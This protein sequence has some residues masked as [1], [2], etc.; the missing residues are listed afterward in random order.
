MKISTTVAAF[1]AFLVLTATAQAGPLHIAARGGDTEAIADLLANGAAVHVQDAYGNTPL[2]AAAMN[3]HVAAIAALRAAGADPNARNKKGRTPLHLA[4]END[5]EPA[6]A[7]LQRDLASI[8]TI[9]SGIY[10]DSTCADP[11]FLRIYV[12]DITIDI[13]RSGSNDSVS[14][15]HLKPDSERLIHGWQR[16]RVEYSDGETFDHFLRMGAAD[17]V[18]SVWWNPGPRKAEEPPRNGWTNVLPSGEADATNYWEMTTYSRCDTVSFPLSMLHG[19]PAAF[20]LSLEPAF[21]TCRYGHPTCI[22]NAFSAADVHADGALSTAEWSRLI[23]VALYFALAYNETTEADKLGAAYAVSLLAVPLAAAALV[24][25]YDY[26]GD[27]RTSLEELLQAMAGQEAAPV[28]DVEGVD[29]E[30]RKKLG[31]AMTILRN[32]SRQVPGL[33]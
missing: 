1:A 15:G 7:A 17:Q 30:V 19:E 31:Q 18:Q 16:F 2:H 3:G 12:P 20:L 27:G 10:T 23:R 22:E 33:D 6:V 32:L 25:S 28:P 24:S 13:D 14:L 4:R 29:S 8:S 5:D 11:S 9:R 21:H 26:D